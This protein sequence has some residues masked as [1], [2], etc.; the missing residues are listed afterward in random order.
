MAVVQ[1]HKDKYIL[2]Q[3]KRGV[4]VVFREAFVNL[5]QKRVIVICANMQWKRQIFPASVYFWDSS[6]SEKSPSAHEGLP[7]LSPGLSLLWLKPVHRLLT[8][9]KVLASSGENIPE[10]RLLLVLKFS[11][12]SN[13]IFLQDIWIEFIVFSEAY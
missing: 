12:S 13:F 8:V 3:P 9:R 2:K 1:L 10:P 4:S 11:I 7:Q 5:A 6:Q